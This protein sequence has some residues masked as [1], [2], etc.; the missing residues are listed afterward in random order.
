VKPYYEHGGITI[1]HAD[2]REALPLLSADVM[3]TDPPYGVNKAE[4]DAEFVLPPLVPCNVLGLMP[5]TINILSCP[6]GLCGLQYRWTLSAYL[7][8]GM[9]RGAMGFANWIP[10]LVYAREGVSVYGQRQDAK[11]FTVGREP[12]PAHPSPKP[13]DVTRWFLSCLPGDTVLDPF[14]GS[15]TTLRAAK[16]LGRRAIGIELD[17]RWC[18]LAARRLSQ[19]VLAF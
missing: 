19:E 4:W 16:D 7:A 13:L 2:C 5:G 14:M 1:Y 11:K 17:E 18:E 6:R 8:N 9:T 10:C 12:K 15:G 3:L